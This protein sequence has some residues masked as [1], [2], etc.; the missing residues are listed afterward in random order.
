MPLQSG[1]I[2]YR[3]EDTS[4]ARLKRSGDHLVVVAV[5]PEFWRACEFSQ[6][7]AW[8]GPGASKQFSLVHPQVH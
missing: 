5:S 1:R 2:E 8:P 3:T 6:I 7:S 4:A